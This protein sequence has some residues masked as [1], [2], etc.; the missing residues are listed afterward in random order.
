MPRP[1]K[2]GAC[3]LKKFLRVV[4]FNRYLC[5]S[6]LKEYLIQKDGGS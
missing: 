5:A 3:F 4:F 1:S 2:D 6:S